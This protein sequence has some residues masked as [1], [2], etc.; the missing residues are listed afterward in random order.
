MWKKIKPYVI[1]IAIALAVGG[2]SALITGDNM[3]VYDTLNT[4][5]LSPPSFIFGIVWPILYVLMGWSL[6][7]MFNHVVAKVPL[8]GLVL[9]VGGGIFYTIG[10]IFFSIDTRIKYMHYIWHLFVLLGTITQYFFI[11]FY[12]IPV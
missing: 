3:N 6:V 8:K 9:L 5:P 4:P 7:F 2:L 12:V 11:L 10:I 1:S